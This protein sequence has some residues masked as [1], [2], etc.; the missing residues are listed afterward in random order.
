VSKKEYTWIE[1]FEEVAK[2]GYQRGYLYSHGPKE[3]R[4][5]D[6]AAIFTCAMEKLMESTHWH[7]KLA[8]TDPP[9]FELSCKEYPNLIYKIENFQVPQVVL[10]KDKNITEQVYKEIVNKK[11]NKYGDASDYIL[12]VYLRFNGPFNFSDTHN[13]FRH[14]HPDFGQIWIMAAVNKELTTWHCEEVW[15]GT[16][17]IKIDLQEES[18][19]LGKTLKIKSLDKY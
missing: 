13:K 16:Q 8:E 4:E 2:L 15:P 19:K 10:G 7:L 14:L 11:V 17:K 6:A 18:K 5:L 12:C 3:Y 1:A 9:D